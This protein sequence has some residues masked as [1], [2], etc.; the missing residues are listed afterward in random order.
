MG[1]S[2]RVGKRAYYALFAGKRLLENGVDGS[3]CIGD[4][5]YFQVASFK[6]AIRLPENMLSP[7]PN[8]FAVKRRNSV[9]ISPVINFQLERRNG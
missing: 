3:G 7:Q 5:L 9:T 1:S 2:G 4:A 6:S 8:K